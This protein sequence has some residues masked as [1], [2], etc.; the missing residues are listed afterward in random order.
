M[1]VANF[2]CRFGDQEMLD[3]LNEI[4]IPALFDSKLQRTYGNSSYFFHNVTFVTLDESRGV[5]GVFGKL[6]KDTILEREQLFSQELGLVADKERIRSSPSSAFLLV[7]N[8]HRLLFVEE[9]KYA[10]SLDVFCSTIQR[11]LSRKHKEY[12]DALYEEAKEHSARAL[13]AARQTK[14]QFQEKVMFPTVEITPIPSNSSIAGFIQQFATLRS[15][16]IHVLETNSEI[17]NEPFF[18]QAR[19][20]GEILGSQ[21]TVIRHSN[22]TGLDTKEAIKQVDAAAAQGVNSVKLAGIDKE[23]ATLSGDNHDIKVKVP[24]DGFNATPIGAAR[25]LYAKY[26][27]LLTSKIIGSA[28]VGELSES[29]RSQLNRAAE[30]GDL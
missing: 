29:K 9:T 2:V 1:E 27:E 5:Y 14:K 11:F 23:G 21:K 16:E 28:K 22:T 6:V 3:H 12:I 20:L 10:P 13:S 17:D 19:D 24:L 8:D 15:L 18:Q 25:Q 4:V 30:N 7:L 26:R